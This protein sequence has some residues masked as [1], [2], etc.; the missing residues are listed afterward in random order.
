MPAAASAATVPPMKSRLLIMDKMHR[1][2][3]WARSSRP[4]IS[5]SVGE[6]T[7]RFKPASRKLGTSLGNINRNF[8]LAQHGMRCCH[9]HLSGLLLRA[10]P[11]CTSSSDQRERIVAD[12]LSRA[13]DLELNRV[14]CKG[15]DIVEFVGDSKHDTGRVSSVTDQAGVVRPKKELRINPSA[16][17]APRDCKLALDV[18]L[19]TQVIPL[20]KELLQFHREGSIFQ[21]WELHAVGV[22]FGNQLIGNVELHVVAVG[23][24]HGLRKPDGGVAAGP[25]KRRLEHDLLCWIAL[26][27]IKTGCRFR[28]AED[29]GHA[30]VAD[31][32]AR[33]EISVGV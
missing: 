8:L 32:I 30:V 11:D 6:D 1:L 14:V 3:R 15:A 13:F 24:D 28:L 4:N 2:S 18:S 29:V 9:S 25:V 33:A 7:R 17:V 10:D 20:V 5:R 19:E 27:L 31:A 16:G 12:D 23:A 21:V 22:G 26:R